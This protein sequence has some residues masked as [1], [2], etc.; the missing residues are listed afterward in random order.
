MMKQS[1][2]DRLLSFILAFVMMISLFAVNTIG[3]ASAENSDTQAKPKAISVSVTVLG[4]T[5]HDSSVQHSIDTTPDKL[6][7]WVKDMI[8]TVEDGASIYDAIEKALKAKGIEYSIPVSSWGPSIA[9]INGLANGDNG[10]ESF[11]MTILNG[12]DWY[13]ATLSEGDKITVHYADSYN[14]LVESRAPKANV[15]VSV[16]GDTEHDASVSH[17]IDTNP[18]ELLKWVDK[19]EVTVDEG[20]SI[21]DAIEKA[22]KAEGIEYSIPVSSWG[23]SIASINGLAND[24][25][26]SGT[27]Y[28]MTNLNG[29]SWNGSD[30]LKNGDDLVVHFTDDYNLL[31]YDKKPNIKVTVSVYGDTKHDDSEAHCIDTDATGL[32]AWVNKVTVSVADG[33]SYYDVL[34]AALEAAGIDYSIPEG[35][36]GPYI[37]SINGLAG[38][39]NGANSSWLTL[40]NDKYWDAMT[41]PATGDE[42]LVYF[43]DDYN[44]VDWNR[45]NE[46]PEPTP[47]PTPNNVKLEDIYKTT[48]AYLADKNAKPVFGAEWAILGLARAGYEVPKDFYK[49][50]YESVC[51][52]VKSAEGVLSSSKTTEYSRTIIALTAAGYDATDVAGYNLLEGLADCDKIVKQGLSAACYA[53]IAL[54]CGEYEIPTTNSR[55]AVTSREALISYILDAQLK[56]GGFSYGGESADVDMTA[57]VIQALAPYVKSKENVKKVVDQAVECL[58]KLQNDDATFSSYGDKNVESA[59]QVLVALTALGIDPKTDKRFVKN[60]KTVLDAFNLFYIENGGFS[61]LM[62]AD[63]N[64][65]A[66]VQGYYALAAYFRF[67]DGKSALY[68]MKTV[69]PDEPESKPDDPAKEDKGG[70]NTAPAA[71]ALLMMLS[72]ASIFVLKRKSQRA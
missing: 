42:I 65:Y 3:V 63:L 32:E 15:T 52:A 17:C 27:A 25:S 8:V 61:H 71:Y 62:N 37:D 24:Y 64:D 57:I 70:D 49:N 21:Y 55:A 23:P 58:S 46:E 2:K 48:G 7:P 12:S 68:D 31:S 56:D 45:G 53:L 28:W 51:E 72:A 4:D 16:Y 1:L 22:L 11:W 18:D 26:G 60:D 50:Y 29:V 5:K 30:T 44:D 39:D 69:N 40:L 43:V 66:T 9:S 34:A 47:E 33:S 20:A 38:G 10:S 36:W 59:S 14:L 6:L 67:A 41:A 19:A 13:G 54:D 35:S